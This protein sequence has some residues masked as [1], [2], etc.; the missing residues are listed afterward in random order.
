MPTLSRPALGSTDWFSAVDNNWQALQT[1]L[2]SRK[3]Q[4]STPSV[5]AA[6][7]TWYETDTGITWVSDGTYWLSQELFTACGSMNTAVAVDYWAPIQIASVSAF[8]IYAVDI[9]AGIYVNVTNDATRYWTVQLRTANLSATRTS[10]GSP[11]STQGYTAN[12]FYTYTQSINSRLTSVGNTQ[13]VFVF[14][15]YPQGSTP[16]GFVGGFGMSYRL[17]HGA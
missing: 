17:E 16:G 7:D 11:L 10:V 13:K 8:N 3:V 9:F 4:S 1:N 14:E 5:G 2:D 15:I 12:Q 6:G